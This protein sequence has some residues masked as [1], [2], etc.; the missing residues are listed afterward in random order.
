M[1]YGYGDREIYEAYCHTKKAKKLLKHWLKRH[2]CGNPDGFGYPPYG[3]YPYQTPIGPY[4][5]YGRY[6]LY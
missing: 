6:P 2:R 4:Q 5:P 3:R 1:D